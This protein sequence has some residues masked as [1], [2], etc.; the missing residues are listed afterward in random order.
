MDIMDELNLTE[1]AAHALKQKHPRIIKCAR[2]YIGSH[3]DYSITLWS[4][5][6]VNGWLEDMLPYAVLEDGVEVDWYDNEEDAQDIKELL[7][8]WAKEEGK[9]QTYTIEEAI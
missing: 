2:N 4:P 1:R 7:E 9:S 3:E 5:K 8:R 6:Q